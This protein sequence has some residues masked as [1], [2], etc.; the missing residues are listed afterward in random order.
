MKQSSISDS[1]SQP[2]T[3]ELRSVKMFRWFGASATL[4]VPQAAAPVAFSLVALS[5]VG[6][7][8]FGAAMVLA[9]TLAQVVGAIPIT[10]LGRTW[11]AVSYLRVLTIFRTVA[12]AGIAVGAQYQVHFS[13][14]VSLAALA[15]LVNGATYAFLRT[16]L[17]NLT[18]TSRLP[19]A[20]GIAAT[21]N[22]VTFVLGPV[23]AS[24]AGI[25]SPAFAVALMAV[26]GGLPALLVP[27]SDMSGYEGVADPRRSIVT[28]EIALWLCCAAAGSGT[29]AAIEIGAVGLALNFGY[30]PGYAIMFTV[31]LCLASVAGGIWIS[32]RNRISTK[33]AVL[34]Q[35]S[36]LSSGISFVAIGGTVSTIIFG[37][38]FVGLMLAPLGTYYA[39]ILDQLAPSHKRTEVFALL[40][41]S[42]AVGVISTSALLIALPLNT[43]LIVIAAMM[44]GVTTILYY[45]HRHARDEPCEPC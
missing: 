45:F 6:D 12:L 18:T 13:L 1:F 19:R 30:A 35:L 25:I 8:R 15:G 3:S 36:I 20:L 14:I 43:A 38:V 24:S 41:T 11:P 42:S 34:V 22:E 16:I 37:S 4:T 17:N 9:M 33:R 40:R 5:I 7:A 31:P 39:L 10:R 32:V 21:L 29:V 27:K 23:V 26:L 2:G 28:K 44:W